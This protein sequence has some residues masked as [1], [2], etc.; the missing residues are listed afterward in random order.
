MSYNPVLT[1]DGEIAWDE[2]T[3]DR[4]P[5]R[6]EAEPGTNALSRLTLR[7]LGLLPIEWLL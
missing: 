6:H 1:E 4:P 7:L 5:R 3:P 2:A